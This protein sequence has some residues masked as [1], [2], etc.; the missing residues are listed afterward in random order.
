MRIESVRWLLRRARSW[1]RRCSSWERKMR[2]WF[3]KFAS[4]SE[5]SIVL[6]IS[7][8]VCKR[9]L[10]RWKSS[11]SWLW[12]WNE[13]LRIWCES[14]S[15]EKCRHRLCHEMALKWQ[16]R[17]KIMIRFLDEGKSRVLILTTRLESRGRIVKKFRFMMIFQW[18][19]LS[20][21]R[22]QLSLLGWRICSRWSIQ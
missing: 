17:L 22:W 14:Q 2:I 10:K 7:L 3:R 13:G 20:F 19:T 12:P 11:I 8:K 1:L 9:I 21:L 16:I 15:Q 4:F 5:I 6:R 18:S